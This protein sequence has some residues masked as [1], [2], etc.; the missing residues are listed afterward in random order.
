MPD[1]PRTIVIGMLGCGVVGSGTLRTLQENAAAIERLL[2][3]RLVVKKVCVRTLDKPRAVELPRSL[4]TTDAAEIVDD[5]DVQIVAEL[6]GGIEPAGSYIQRALHNGKHVVTANKELIAKAGSQLLV[7]AAERQRDFFFE[8]AVAGGIPI[9]RALKVSLAA[10]RVQE[11]MGIVNGTTNY[12]LT[13][14]TQNGLDFGVALAEA[15][16]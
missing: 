15:Q 14:M 6:I 10:N 9:I 4:F 3:A 11:V 5:P 12:I 8:G 16:A 7:E 13:Q 1:Q 2:N